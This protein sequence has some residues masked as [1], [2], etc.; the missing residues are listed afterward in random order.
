MDTFGF[1]SGE[2]KNFF[3]F[4]TP[5]QLQLAAI[6]FLIILEVM[7]FHRR[8]LPILSTRTF[9]GILVFSLIFV[10]SDTSIIFVSKL[11][12]PRNWGIRLVSQLRLYTYLNMS[13]CQYL[14]IT[15]LQGKRQHI[16][17]KDGLKIFSIY[18]IGVISIF[19]VN[20]FTRNETQGY[21]AYDVI[22]IINSCISLLY[23]TMTIIETTIFIKKN[24][25]SFFRGKKR[26]IYWTTAVWIIIALIQIIHSRTTVSSLGVAAMCFLMYMGLET[27]GNYIDHDTEAMKIGRA[28]V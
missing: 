11:K 6:V 7:F 18:G 24:P 27:P 19:G 13:L 5:I 26:Y 10:I 25:D 4:T 8:R 20:L 17:I 1:I 21:F 2:I 28:H 15:L 3:N 12:L 9:I 23:A 16:R 14:Y 22:S